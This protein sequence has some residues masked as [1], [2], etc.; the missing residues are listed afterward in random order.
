MLPAVAQLHVPKV[1][2]RAQAALVEERLRSLASDGS[3]T[4]SQLVSDAVG[5]LEVVARFLAVLTLFKRGRLQFRQPG[6]FERLDLRWVADDSASAPGN[7]GIAGSA[8][9][10]EVHR[11]G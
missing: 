11:H 6:P 2:L 10:L 1:D 5:R 9:G 3:M 4:F 8:R 7:D